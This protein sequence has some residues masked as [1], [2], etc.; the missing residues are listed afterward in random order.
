MQPKAYE[1]YFENGN[2]FTAGRMVSLPEKKRVVITV[3]DELEKAETGEY[4]RRSEWIKKMT[5][6]VI[7]SSNEELCEIPRSTLMREPVDLGK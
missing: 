5:A 6:A 2:F 7:S 4:E 3:L 1:G